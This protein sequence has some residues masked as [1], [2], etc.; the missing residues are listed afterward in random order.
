MAKWTARLIV[1]AAV[2]ALLWIRF[3]IDTDPQRKVIMTGGVLLLTTV[4]GFLWVLLLSG[5]PWRRRLALAGGGLAVIGASFAL[6]EMR[7]VDGNL[8]PILGLRFAPPSELDAEPGAAPTAP[9][10]PS[11]AEQTWRDWPQFLGPTRTATLD[12]VTLERDWD[13]HPPRLVWEREVGPAWSGFAVRGRDAVTQEQRGESE[14]VV[15]YDLE[16]G[17]VRWM[18]AEA[19]KYSTEIGG[20]GPRATPTITE[21]RVFTF[22]ATGILNAL[23]R[24]TGDVIWSHD[25][26]TENGAKVAAWGMSGSPLVLDDMV[27]IAAGGP[28]DGSVV[29]HHRETG[30]RVWGAGDARVGFSS[31]VFATLAGAPQ[32][33]SLNGVSLTAHAPDDGRVLWEFPWSDQNPNVAQPLVLPGDR[34]LTSS[35]YGV[36]CALHHVRRD[37]QGAFH[38][39]E[40]WKTFALKAKFANYVHHDGF[41]YG[42]DEGILVCVDP[43]DGSRRWKGGRY[44]HGQLILVD[45]VLLISEEQGDL[46]LVEATPEE[47][48]ELASFTAFDEKQWNTPALAFPYL[49]VRTERRAACYELR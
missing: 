20:T 46:L 39:D 21:D 41:V 35:G 17:E 28:D 37:E 29:A 33:L 7:G 15:C 9:A 1:V 24:A 49:L 30:E 16:T 38:A 25:V 43:Q 12:D 47:H 18:H 27:V 34:V 3:G 22:G 40:Q 14:C 44:G 36:G 31:P 5:L 2:A 4:A 8:V 48:R 13:A 32:I 6:F 42:L 19:A 45:D 10:T 23:D 26:V 11:S